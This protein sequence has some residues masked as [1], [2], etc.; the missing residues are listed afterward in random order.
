MSTYPILDMACT[1]KLRTIPRSIAVT[2]RSDTAVRLKRPHNG[3]PGAPGQNAPGLVEGAKEQET[4][5]VTKR[6]ERNKV[7]TWMDLMVI[8]DSGNR[9]IPAIP[10]LVQVCPS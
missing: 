3:D 7:A 5:C 9:R 6:K 8:Q 2:I 1:V 10:Y 4:G